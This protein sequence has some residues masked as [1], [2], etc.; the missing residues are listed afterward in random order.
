MKN[1]LM[2]FEFLIY[3]TGGVV[4]LFLILA[5]TLFAIDIYNEKE[6]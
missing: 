6:L 3:C 1:A 2:V 4:T 5:V